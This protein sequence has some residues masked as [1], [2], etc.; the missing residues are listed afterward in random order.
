MGWPSNLG[1]HP[2]VLAN[3]YL[4]L[5]DTSTV[6]AGFPEKFRSLGNVEQQDSCAAWYSP[7][8]QVMGVEPMGI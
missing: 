5:L 3:V 8:Q 4:Y 1:Q 2:Y 6:G 7:Y